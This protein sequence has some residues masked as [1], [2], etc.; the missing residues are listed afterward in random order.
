VI[1]SE[2]FLQVRQWALVTGVTLSIGF[3]LVAWFGLRTNDFVPMLI[4]SIAGFELALLGR[5][6]AEKR[7]R[8]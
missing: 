5:D 8:G 2:T 6:L 7:L 4:A 3:F 1:G